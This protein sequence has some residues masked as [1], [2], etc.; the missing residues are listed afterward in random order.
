[1]FTNIGNKNKYVIKPRKY[2]LKL[3]RKSIG[4]KSIGSR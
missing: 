3:Y 2:P 1:M 4:R